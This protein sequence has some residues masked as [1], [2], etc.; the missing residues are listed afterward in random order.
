MKFLWTAGC[1]LTVLVP[2]AR[3]EAA[4]AATLSLDWGTIAQN[5]GW[6]DGQ[7]NGRVSVGEGA[8]ALSLE[9]GSGVS[10]VGLNNDDMTP[11]INSILNGSAPDNDPSLHLQIDADQI[12]LVEGDYSVKLTTTFE[13]YST[14]LTDV[15][16][17]LYDIDISEKDIKKK[18]KPLWQDRVIV[19]GFLGNQLIAPVFDWRYDNTTSLQLVDP[20]TLDGIA[21][22]DNNADTSNVQVSFAGAIDRFELV[23]TD[24]DNIGTIDPGSHGIGIGD[25]Q[26]TAAEDIPEPSSLLGVLTAGLTLGGFKLR[27]SSANQTL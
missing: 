3:P 21:P 24:G 8:I 22:V 15:S 25:I 23:F 18:K 16:F 27:K 9:S 26:F 17:P 4:H 11:A 2:I 10:F 1:V 14:L 20:Y 19:R 5:G 13:G 7:Q 12:G 6:I